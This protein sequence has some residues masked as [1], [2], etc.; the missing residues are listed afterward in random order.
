MVLKTRKV[1]VGVPE[2]AGGDMMDFPPP[3]LGVSI[4]PL[5]RMPQS[6]TMRTASS[7]MPRVLP[8]P[9]LVKTAKPISTGTNSIPA[10]IT[11][12]A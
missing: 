10:F 11:P 6:S 1:G 9:A 5:K 12:A 4:G 8:P 7:V 3:P 2:L